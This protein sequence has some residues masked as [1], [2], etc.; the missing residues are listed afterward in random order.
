MLSQS[1]VALSA[2]PPAG[3]APAPAQSAAPK[4]FSIL[5]YQI[6][7]NTVLPVDAIERAV[8]PFLGPDKTI[9][10][11]EAARVK[12][13][14]TYHERG[15]KTVLVDIPQQRV[16][17]G[18][19]RLHVTEAPVGKLRIQGSK[20]HSLEVIREH[21]EQFAPG[22]VPNFP[23][24]QKELGTVNGSAD[25]R[26]TPVLRASDT[27]GKVDVDLQVEDRLPLH[28]L[29]QF[30][31]RYSANTTHLRTTGE[32]HY[33]NLF[34]SN[35]SLNFQYQIAPLRTSDAKIASLSYVIPTASGGP[36]WALYAIH[37]DSNIAAVGNLNVIGAGNIFGLRW[38]DPLPTNSAFFYHSFTAGVDYK[39]FKQSVVLEGAESTIESPI[40]YPA[41]TLDYSGTW[42][43]AL[44]SGKGVRAA[45][46]GGRSSL[47]I[48]V[49][50][51]FLVR[52][53]GTDW[54]QFAHKRAHADDSFIVLHPSIVAEQVLPFSWSLAEKVDGQLASG[55]L[56]NNEQYSAGGADNVRGYVEAERLG[57]NAVRGSLELRTPQWL[58]AYP[59]IDQAYLGLFVDGAKAF[60]LQPL[61][62]QEATY[63]LSSAGLALRFKTRGLYVALDGARILQ[64]GLVTPK[65]RFRGLFKVTYEY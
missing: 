23:E 52:G 6:E 61:S 30:D 55:P 38:I 4:P 43:G 11:I 21:V 44:P 58:T 32:I 27:P 10:D 37:S 40:K 33:D 3:P 31:N 63:T 41:F 20:Y 13:E 15:F 1:L 65:D 29:L 35:Q 7:G 49:G 53:L 8:T 36:V 62:G 16:A 42:L 60:T 26:V 57:D 56:I 28:A 18:I 12:L 39:D 51:T 22:T 25:L 17:D 14:A 34:Q 59:K 24:V 54:Q 46:S 50:I 9:K 64:E 48:D 5:E 19:V 47:S 45:T 2:E